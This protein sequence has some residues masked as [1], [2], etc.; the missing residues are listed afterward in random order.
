MPRRLARISKVSKHSGLHL[1]TNGV[2]AYVESDSSVLPAEK[3]RA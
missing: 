2:C 1:T 3:T